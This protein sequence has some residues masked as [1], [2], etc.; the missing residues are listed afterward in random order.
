MENSQQR[1]SHIAL[2]QQLVKDLEN[3]RDA[4]TNLSLALHDAKFLLDG[5]QIEVARRIAAVCLLRSQSGY[6]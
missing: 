2:E 6:K 4:L 1:P 5:P 3:M